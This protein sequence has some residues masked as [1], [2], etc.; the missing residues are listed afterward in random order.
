MPEEHPHQRTTRRASCLLWGL[1]AAVL[2]LPLGL[3][4]YLT[5]GPNPAIVVSRATTH[6]TTPLTADGLPDYAAALLADMRKG[7]TP[8]NNA[9]VPF[10][11]AMWPADA[12]GVEN[13]YTDWDLSAQEI[14][15]LCQELGLAGPTPAVQRYQ[16]FETAEN[17]LAVLRWLRD[18]MKGPSS[19]QVTAGWNRP[20]FRTDQEFLAASEHEALK[21]ERVTDTLWK[22]SGPPRP[23]SRDEAPPFAEWIDRVSPNLDLLVEGVERPAWSFPSMSLLRGDRGLF[24]EGWIWQIMQAREAM[25]TLHSRAMLFSGEGRHEDA[26]RDVLA[27]LML[28]KHLASEP[29]LSERD[30]RQ[31]D[32]RSR[33]PQSP[34][35]L[36]L[37]RNS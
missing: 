23:W 32:G 34:S 8:A 15:A 20:P 11:K 37:T 19:A 1:I 24:S 4:L 16:Q 21:D 9:A 36:V 28:S 12:S 26:I 33:V 14:Q 35:A 5:F 27:I 2:V 30:R 3:G 29:T 22:I 13:A 17:R 18:P 10:L 7:V 25:R 6:L 31:R